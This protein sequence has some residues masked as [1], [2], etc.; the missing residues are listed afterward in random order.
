MIQIVATVAILLAALVVAIEEHASRYLR[1]LRR[2][3]RLYEGRHILGGGLVALAALTALPPHADAQQK[4]KVSR[5]AC[6]QVV[7]YTQAPGVAY[8]PGVD[9]MGRPVASADLAGGIQVQPRTEFT[10]D[11]TVDMGK[12]FGVSPKALY[13]AQANVGQIT[14]RGNQAYFDGQPLTDEGQAALAQL[15]Q[16]QFGQ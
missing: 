13:Q 1:Q 10:I 7:N 8:Q 3:R 11:L 16:Q 9:A 4:L 6:N 15:C 5:E 14:V 2:L 12:R